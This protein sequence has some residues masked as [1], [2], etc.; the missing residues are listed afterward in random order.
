[1]TTPWSLITSTAEVDVWFEGPLVFSYTDENPLLK[2]WEVQE[3]VFWVYVYD[4][5]RSLD[6]YRRPICYADGY[7]MLTLTNYSDPTKKITLIEFTW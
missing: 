6:Y 7:P 4:P 5:D 3:L 2:K 1:M